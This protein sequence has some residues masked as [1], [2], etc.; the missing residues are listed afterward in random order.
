MLSLSAQLLVVMVSLVVAAIVALTLEA[1][2][3]SVRSLETQALR[4]TQLA[5]QAR[6]Q[7]LTQRLELRQQRARGF[8]MSV[9]SICAEPRPTG[10]FGWGEEC[11]RTMLREFG[12]SEGSKGA[13][14]TYRNRVLATYGRPV[15]SGEAAPDA[16]AWLPY[17]RDSNDYALRVVNGDVALGLLFDGVEIDRYFDQPSGLGRT[18]RVQ[19]VDGVDDRVRAACRTGAGQ[20][21]EEGE[22][23][24]RTIVG[25][26]PVRT[27]GDACIEAALDYSEAVAP[28]EELRDALAQRGVWFAL[29]GAV[30]SLVLA[31]L[32]AAPVRKLAA[33]ARA[34]QAGDF[35]RRVPI[36]GPREIRELGRAF[37][38]MAVDLASMIEGEQA[39][40]REAE[41][42]NRSK[43][44]FLAML[45]HEM[46]TPLNAILGWTRL[47][48]SG[49]LD[50]ARAARALASVENSANAQRRLIEDLLDVSQIVAGRLRMRRERTALPAITDAALEAVRP[51]A[52]QRGVT[53]GWT[54][55]DPSLSLM[56]DSQRLQQ[57]VWN[58]AWNAIKFTPEGGRVHVT[59]ARDGQCA[60]LSV[61]DTGVG[62]SAEFLPHVFEWYRQDE[63]GKGISEAGV[64]LGLALVREL[65]ALHGGT[66][67]AE[68]E[69][70]GKGATF[71]V[72]LPLEQRRP[73]THDTDTVA[74]PT[75]D[76]LSR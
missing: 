19:L 13:T 33:S 55:D 11:T 51:L 63:S 35:G 68:S 76:R 58:L 45:S 24:A 66:V 49:Q 29:L 48:Q 41:T 28:A 8:L 1:H 2:R 60:R 43:D 54:I 57:V 52:E 37:V 70:E 31:Q 62:I 67:H 32:I 18:G 56:G 25:Y 26:A 46:R 17:P 3:A 47:L 71:I 72:S 4:E 9:E 5:V 16:I 15:P 50:A 36:A 22:A 61:S 38:G 39:A 44:R 6:E 20:T 64:G 27:L 7:S 75:P 53:L 34:L 65:V 59:L 30:V 42:A 74:R 12:A 23:G 40:R 14:L 10:G 21:I 73:R 69:G